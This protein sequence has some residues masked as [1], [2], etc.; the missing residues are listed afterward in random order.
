M[1]HS[2]H[3]FP[4][5]SFTLSPADTTAE[6]SDGVPS[7]LENAVGCPP[8]EPSYHCFH[9]LRVINRGRSSRITSFPIYYFIGRRC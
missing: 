5:I 3:Y 6:G 4:L 7:L 1:N 9:L 2:F 8:D